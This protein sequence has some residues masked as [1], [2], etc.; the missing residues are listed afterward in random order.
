MFSEHLHDIK[1]FKYNL[2]SEKVKNENVNI[3][4]I[5]T[6]DVNN[7]ELVYSCQIDARGFKPQ[8]K[9]DTP[10]NQGKAC[11]FLIEAFHQN[12][13]VTSSQSQPVDVFNEV[14]KILEKYMSYSLVVVVYEQSFPH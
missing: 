4:I 9:E 1:I 5:E 13:K 12:S 11:R 14:D 7:P 6:F 3:Y 2:S 8:S 10:N